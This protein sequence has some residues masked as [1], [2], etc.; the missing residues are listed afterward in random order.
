MKKIILFVLLISTYSFSQNINS[1]EFNKNM[2]SLEY[3]I[4]LR[5]SQTLE[6]IV[7]SKNLGLMSESQSMNLVINPEGKSFPEKQKRNLIGMIKIIFNNESNEKLNPKEVS[8][9]YFL[10]CLNSFSK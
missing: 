1:D 8:T 6:K 7:N 3:N 10:N 9:N 5:S 2:L 4:C